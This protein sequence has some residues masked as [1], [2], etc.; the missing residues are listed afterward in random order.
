MLMLENGEG[1]P[2]MFCWLSELSEACKANAETTVGEETAAMTLIPHMLWYERV[3]Y[4]PRFT[5][6]RP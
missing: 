2:C 3:C 5:S 6:Q 4:S 1:E